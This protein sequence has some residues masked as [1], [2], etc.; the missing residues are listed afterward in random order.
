MV[1]RFRPLSLAERIT[2]NA[3]IADKTTA[4]FWIS[5]PYECQN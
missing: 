3:A 1:F 5:E 4:P 2:A